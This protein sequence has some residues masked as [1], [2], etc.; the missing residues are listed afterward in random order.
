MRV[1]VRKRGFLGIRNQEIYSFLFRNRKSGNLFPLD[2][3]IS[4]VQL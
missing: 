1:S 2:Y 3:D 4:I